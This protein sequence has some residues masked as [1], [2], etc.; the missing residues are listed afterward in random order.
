MA[1]I[2]ARGGV[3][4]KRM[5]SLSVGLVNPKEDDRSERYYRVEVLCLSTLLL[6]QI[7]LVVS[8]SITIAD[9]S[10]LLPEV[11][12]TLADIQAASNLLDRLC[13]TVFRDYCG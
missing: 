6:L 10:A 3:V 11:K 12:T 8:I 9:V 7:F 5:E 1:T 13:G 2:K 4:V